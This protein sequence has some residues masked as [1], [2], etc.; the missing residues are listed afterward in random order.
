MKKLMFVA[1]AITLVLVAGASAK[2]ASK[3]PRLDGS[4]RVTATIQNNDIGI[5]PGSVTSD[6][7]VFKSSCPKGACKTVGL[8]RESG[9]RDVKSTLKRTAPRVYKGIEGPEPYVCINPIG[10]KGTFTGEHKITVTKAKKGKATRI[11]GKTVI[12]ISGCIET[13]EDVKLK[14]KLTQ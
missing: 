2:K 12:H 7:Y 5:Q 3:A 1:M 8:T 11:T 6:V 10:A 4:F 9:E 14:G 13:F